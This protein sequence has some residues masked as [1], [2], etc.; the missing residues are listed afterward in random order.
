MRFDGSLGFSGG[1]I[2]D[3]EDVLT[4]LA[5]ELAEEI[6]LDTSIHSLANATRITTNADHSRRMIFHFFALE[7]SYTEFQG[8]ERKCFDAADYSV[9]A[10]VTLELMSD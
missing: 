7:M 5:R 2:D 4:G 3:G 6:K 1:I 8:V 10:C 9:E